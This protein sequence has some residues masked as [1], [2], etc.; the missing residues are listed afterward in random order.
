MQQ[1]QQ[2]LPLQEVHQPP[3][4]AI[5]GRLL[6]PWAGGALG[7]QRLPAPQDANL[8][9]VIS[10]GIKATATQTADLW[11]ASE[12]PTFVIA[13]G[14]GTLQEGII[15]P[16]WLLALDEVAYVSET[17]T[18]QLRALPECVLEYFHPP[19]PAE[20]V[21]VGMPA[22]LQFATF[23]AAFLATLEY[24]MEGAQL[25]CKNRVGI[26]REELER[27]QKTVGVYLWHHFKTLME[28]KGKVCEVLLTAINGGLKA[29]VIDLARKGGVF[30]QK[31]QYAPPP[32]G[33]G[34]PMT[35]LAFTRLSELV[36]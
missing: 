19:L 28:L 5:A 15:R 4:G 36:E 14:G 16:L 18:K 11:H 17:V 32:S 1:P 23:V 27:L 22:E 20:Q 10:A 9:A 8:Q 34:I 35:T 29:R 13:R 21:P 33:T 6:A 12:G 31:Y 26:L 3:G 25:V 7:G 24:G 2:L 30:R